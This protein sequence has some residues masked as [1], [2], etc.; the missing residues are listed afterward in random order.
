MA[1]AE[2]SEA[3]RAL[4]ARRWDPSPVVARAVQ[5]VV[6]RRA[7][8]DASQRAALEA[9]ITAPGGESRDQD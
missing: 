5:T 6:T 7:E 8:L 2:T 1:D 3:A 9:A 4:A